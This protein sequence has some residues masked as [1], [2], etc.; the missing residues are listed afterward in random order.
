MMS[1]MAKPVRSSEVEQFRRRVKVIWH[2]F[3]TFVAGAAARRRFGFA[4]DE[5]AANGVINRACQFRAIGGE[6]GLRRMP[7]G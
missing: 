6:R 3:G 5:A 1:A 4:D 7:L 2:G